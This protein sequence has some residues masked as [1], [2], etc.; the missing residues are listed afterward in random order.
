MIM[1]SNPRVPF[2]LSSSRFVPAAPQGKPLI[3][4]IVVNVEYWPFDQPMPRALFQKP[5][6]VSHGPDIANFCWVEHGLRAGIPRLLRVFGERGLPVSAA[7]NA[8][9]IDVYPSVAEAV[10]QAGWEFMGHGL[11]QRSLEHEEDEV[12]VIRAALQKMTKFSGRQP[13]SWLGPGLGET[14]DTPDHLAAAGVRYIYEWAID[15]LPVRMRT[16]SDF[17]YAMPYALELNDVTI[18]SLEKHDSHIYYERF[19]D[20]VAVLGLEAAQQPRVLTLALHPHVIAQPHRLAHFCRTLDML[21]ARS[22]TIFMTCD[23]IGDWYHAAV[24]GGG[25]A[26]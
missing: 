6:G 11:Y 23:A 16:K 12:A 4:H 13:R 26:D 22:D 17:A 1:Q 5:H 14:L 25:A 18:F 10:L 9:V 19:K 15:D 8:Q 21:Q 3:C 7:M 20:T 2:E 24:G